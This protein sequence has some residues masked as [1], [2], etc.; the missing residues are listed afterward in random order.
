MI[1]EPSPPIA[2]LYSDEDVDGRLVTALRQRNYDIETA[3]ATSLRGVSDENQSAQRGL[4]LII[5]IFAIIWLVS[6]QAIPDIPVAE[7]TPTVVA[8]STTASSPTLS[9]TETTAPTATAI[10]ATATVVPASGGTA[11]VGMVGHPQTLNP[12]TEPSQVLR[13]LTPLLYSSLLTVDPET[14]ELQPGLAEAW[15][16]S[17]NG[18]RVT[19][20]LPPNIQWSDGTP[21]TA[22]DIVESWQASQHPALRAFSQITALNKQTLRLT[23][24]AIDCAAMTQLALLPL[25]P[26]EQIL[27]PIPLGNGPFTVAEWSENRRTL[28]LTANPNYHA[29]APY[30]DALTLRFMAEDELN[31]AVSEGQFDAVGPIPAEQMSSLTYGEL[32]DLAYAEAQLVYIALNFEPRNEPP[33]LPLVRQALLSALDREEILTQA[34]AGDGQL[35]AASL[36]PEHWAANNTLSPPAYDPKTAR[37]LLAKAGLKD[38]DDDGWLDKNGKRVNLAVQLHGNEPLHQRIGWLVA[39]YYRELGL[40]A[41]AES[42]SSD[43]LLDNLF[44]HDFDQAIFRWPMLA[45]PDQRVF[46]HSRENKEGEGLNFV[47]YHNSQLDIWQEDA[48]SVAGC[49]LDDRADIYQE[50]QSTLHKDRPVDFILTPNQHVLVDSQLQGLKP[51]PFTP[52][53]W[54]V[55]KW[56]LK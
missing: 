1:T 14:A 56:F 12:I 51:G 8:Q 9:P 48:V 4:T 42:I 30:L 28:K 25:L 20:T 53:T 6:C 55:T 15:A 35:L 34:L 50:I 3:V 52:F 49:Q 19:F 10:P 18:K 47:S 5:A 33:L 24:L 45:D 21:L 23:F 54:N 38:S 13:Q 11:L 16:Y 43:I 26:A 41:R 17:P 32:T 36:L 46:W 2:Q 40:F 31:L 27:E 22:A 44:T 39:S 37:N 7:N 29:Q